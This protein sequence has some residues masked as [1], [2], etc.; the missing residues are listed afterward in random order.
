MRE[1]G[2]GGSFSPTLES[3]LVSPPFF[4]RDSLWLEGA[5]GRPVDLSEAEW[6][7][8]VYVCVSLSPAIPRSNV[9]PGPS[10]RPAPDV[11]SPVVVGGACLTVCL[12][13]SR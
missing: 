10:T 5:A 8:P 9:A 2:G 7:H 6:A 12:L 4:P 1:G 13:G 3:E 11:V